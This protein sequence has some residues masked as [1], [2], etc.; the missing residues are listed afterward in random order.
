MLNGDNLPGHQSAVQSSLILPVPNND[1]I[2][3]VFTTD[4]TEDN[5]ANGYRYSI[6]NMK[7]DGGKGEVVTK[8]ILLNASCTERLNAARHANGI[9]VW[10]IGNERSSNIFKAWLFTCSGLQTTPVIA[11]TGTVLK[12]Q[13]AQNLG[14]MKVSPDGKQLCQTHFPDFDGLFPENF[15][16]L[17]DFNTATGTRFNAKTITIP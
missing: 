17:L 10:V 11:G 7:H 3:Y 15:F 6:V 14:M 1:S 13:P 2:Y 16:Q 12:Q 8:N 4:A 9:D 5:F